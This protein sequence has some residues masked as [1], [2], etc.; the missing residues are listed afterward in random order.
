MNIDQ[1]FNLGHVVK[2]IGLKGECSIH[3]DVDQTSHYK[4]LESVFIEINKKLIP[5]FIDKIELRQNNFASVFFKGYNTLQQ[6]EQ[7]T[8]CAIYLPLTALP[9]LSENDFY[10]HELEGLIVI[11]DSVGE[12]GQLTE[13]TDYGHSMVAT[14]VYNS[15]EILFPIQKSIAYKIDRQQKKLYVK[16]PQGLLDLYLSDDHTPDDNE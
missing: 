15:K 3:L 13:V 2:A 8:G 4:K 1:C 11:E 10:Y 5:F 7:L 6:A 12:L 16:F 9:S 14:V